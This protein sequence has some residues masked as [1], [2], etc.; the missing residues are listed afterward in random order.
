MTRVLP[1]TWFVGAI[2]VAVAVHFLLP[3]V[4]VFDMPW[5]LI[6]L[7]L[8]LFGILLNLLADRAFKAHNTTVKPF[9]ESTVLVTHGVFGVSRNPMYLGMTLILLGVATLLGSVTPFLVAFLLAALL[10]RVF[11]IPEERML[12]E[13]FGQQYGEYR[14]HVRRWF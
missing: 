4:Q 10:D 8:L 12:N 11:I 14:R 6:G 9:E 13:T 3:L 5:R 1:P 2:V 7:V